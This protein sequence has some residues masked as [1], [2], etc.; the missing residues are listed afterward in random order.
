MNIYL[1]MNVYYRPFDD[2]SQPRI[3][4]ESKAIE[5]VFRLM[6]R[7]Q[8]KVFW[9]YMLEYENS[10][11]QFKEESEDIKAIAD[12]ICSNIIEWNESIDETAKIIVEKS[13]AKNKDALHLACAINTGCEYFITCD[14]KF[15]R[16]INYNREDLQNILGTIKLVN[17]VDFVGKEME[18]YDNE[19]Q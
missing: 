11:N 4:L 9:S 2:Q 1:D 15:I 19:K 17:P 3:E 16:T 7:W 6:E 18:V 10:S 8:Y 5:I 13:N 14:N 12:I